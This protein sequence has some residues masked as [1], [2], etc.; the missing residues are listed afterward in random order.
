MNDESFDLAALDGIPDPLDPP[1]GALRDA[2][3]KGSWESVS[4]A[5][6]E[7]GPSRTRSQ[8]RREHLAALGFGVVWL[9]TVALIAGV[10]PH[11]EALT[12]AVQGGVPMALAFLAFALGLSGG[13]LGFGGRP[14]AL[15]A[16]LALAPIVFGA[17]VLVVRV[18]TES[19]D[20]RSEASCGFVELFSG[21]VPGLALVFAHRR[22]S[23]N[24]AGLRM[25]VLGL[26]VGL[27]AAGM[28]ALHCPDAGAAH[29][30]L[31]HGLPALG[32]AGAAAAVAYKLGRIR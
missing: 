4:S 32:I 14:H 2:G 17:V 10:R 18:P 21:V 26:A 5:L 19:I 22:G 1:R 6:P 24:G 29:V 27:F 28:W 12:L 25:A 31:S 23:A 20:L 9:A 16:I 11:Y 8:L 15:I 7:L 30:L 3:M 13:K